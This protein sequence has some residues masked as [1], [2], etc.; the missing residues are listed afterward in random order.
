[1]VIFLMHFF[2]ILRWRSVNLLFFLSIV[3]LVLTALGL[4]C[5]AQVCLAVASGI[6]SLVAVCGFSLPWLPLLLLL[7]SHF[8]P[9]RL[10]ATPEMAA[11]QAPPSLGFSGKNT[12]VGC[13]LLL[14]CVKVK[15]LRLSTLKLHSRV[16]L[17]ATPWTAVYQA[18]PSMGFS[19]QGYWSGVPSCFSCWGGTSSRCAGSVAVTHGL[20]AQWH[21]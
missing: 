11:H 14:Q 16:R 9:V 4:H 20:V 10:C 2:Y 12:G 6:Y 13:H 21:M 3:C 8:S 5:C 15:S 7:L 19:R 17:L 1:M 18:P